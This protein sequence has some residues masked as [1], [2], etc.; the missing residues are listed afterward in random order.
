MTVTDPKTSD[1]FDDVDDDDL[2]VADDVCPL[3]TPAFHFCFAVIRAAISRSLTV[4]TKGKSPAD[5]DDEAVSS[6]LIGLEVINEHAQ[7]RGNPDDNDEQ[8]EYLTSRLLQSCHSGHSCNS[9]C[10]F[11]VYLPT[12]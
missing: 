1:N 12:K 10:Y 8:V 9:Y 7:L 2:N 11:Y 4:S 3:T 5:D 6:V